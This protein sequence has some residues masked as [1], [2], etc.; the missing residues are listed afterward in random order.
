LGD[1]LVVVEVALST[2]LLV[3]AALLVRSLERLDTVDPGFRPEGVLTARIDMSSAT[4]S[5]S[6]EPGPNRPQVFFQRLL[7]QVGGLPGVAAAGG[8]NRLPLAG[9]IDG[10]GETVAVEG[11]PIGDSQHG[12]QR[13]VTPEYFRVMGMRLLRGRVFSEADTDRSESVV[14]VDE[15]AA[16]RYWPGMDPI[17]RQIARVNPRFPS[18][19]PHWMK[20]VGMVADVRHAGLDSAPRPQFYVPYFRGEWRNAFLVVSTPGDPSKLAMALQRQVAAADPNA[21]VTEVRPMEDLLSASTSQQR[22]RARLLTAFSLLALLLAAAGIYGVMS[23]VV[24]Q[25]T[26]E[27]GVRMAL[28]ARAGD[29][30]G[31][32]LG[33][34]LVLAVAGLAIGGAGALVLRNLIAGLLFETSASDPVAL[35]AAAAL[36][37]ATA[38][39]ACCAPSR[40]AARVDPLIALRHDG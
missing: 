10:Q 33:R 11:T 32:V 39:A 36:L 17:G 23:C 35:G 8:T 16:A 38:L 13:A 30:F 12:D 6:A 7:E 5:T 14:I 26:A 28:G 34:G 29:V 22:F 27:I 40:R 20:V 3:G 24:D 25:R 1:V 4:Y 37:L 2:V 31:M 19:T 21:V 9:V 18:P 15:A